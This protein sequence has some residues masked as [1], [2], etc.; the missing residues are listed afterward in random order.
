M[1]VYREGLDGTS[2]PSC[3]VANAQNEADLKALD[4]KITMALD[5]TE[6][7]KNME[8]TLQQNTTQ[9]DTIINTQLTALINGKR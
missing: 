7:V 5:L 6:T 9:I 3:D 2:A 4:S 8:A 1:M